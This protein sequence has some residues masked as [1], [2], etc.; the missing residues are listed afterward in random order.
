MRLVLRPAADL[1]AGFLP[2]HMYGVA[3]DC[4]GVTERSALVVSP[5]IARSIGVVEIHDGEPARVWVV[6]D[7]RT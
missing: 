1:P 2:D 4:P 7:E 3:V 5:G 6:R